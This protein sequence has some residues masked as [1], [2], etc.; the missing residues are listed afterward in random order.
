MKTKKP[1]RSGTGMTSIRQT[2][3]DYTLKDKGGHI[4]REFQDYGYRLA[5]ELNDL[6]SRSL[7][8]KLAK[9]VDRPL[10]EKALVFVGEANN[11][12][13]K[14]KLFMWSLNKL[15]KGEKLYKKYE[16]KKEGKGEKKRSG[17]GRN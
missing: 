12:K 14:G 17:E 5:V 2:L 13:H 11:V 16:E 9:E 8:I 3:F 4:T 15:K 10:L 1:K 6:K 7:Y